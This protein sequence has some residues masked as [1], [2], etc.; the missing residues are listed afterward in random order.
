MQEPAITMVFRRPYLNLGY[1]PDEPE[2]VNGLPE[3]IEFNAVHN[4]DSIFCLQTRA[5]EGSTPCQITFAQLQAAVERCC[6]WLLASGSTNG[7]GEGEK[8]P[9]PVGILLGSDI[10]IFIY[11]AALLR[12]GTPVSIE[13]TW[14]LS[15]E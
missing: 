7:R 15:L 14:S 1:I 10:T 5:K 3:L 2:G 8:Y 9:A 6:A 13:E 4:P 12:L 11:I